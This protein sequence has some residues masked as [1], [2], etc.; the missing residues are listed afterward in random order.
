MFPFSVF[1]ENVFLGRQK[2]SNRLK[3]LKQ[4]T[5]SIPPLYN[6]R[7]LSFWYFPQKEGGGGGNWGEDSSHK[8]GG[9]WKV[10]ELFFKKRVPYHLFSYKPTLSNCMFLWVNCSVC[11]A[12]LH[13]ISQYSLCFIGKNLVLLNL[14]SRYVIFTS[15]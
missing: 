6:R 1:P 9:G 2:G 7:G 10:G 15:Q 4:Y 13:H 11:F 12:Y 3:W 8:K 14:I 5:C